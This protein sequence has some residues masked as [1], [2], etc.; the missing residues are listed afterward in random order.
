MF[1]LR[2]AGP[3]PE[4]EQDHSSGESRRAAAARGLRAT[5]LGGSSLLARAVRLV[6]ACV[7]LIVAMGILFALLK[8]NGTNG[9]VSEIHGWGRW[10][11]GPFNGMFSLHTARATIA[12]NWGI[13]AVIYLFAGGLIARLIS[14]SQHSS[15]SHQEDS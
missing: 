11:V 3:T 7:V 9:V 12:V 1:R 2:P 5:A 6:A 4:V 14:R 8:A 15:T 10:L 13:A